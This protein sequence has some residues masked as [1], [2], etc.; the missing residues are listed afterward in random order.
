MF[1]N[2]AFITDIQDL[3]KFLPL[4]ILKIQLNKYLSNSIQPDL[5]W[6]GA[7]L[8]DLQISLQDKLFNDSKPMHLPLCISLSSCILHRRKKTN[9]MKW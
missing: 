4:E 7:R 5:H 8:N 1:E 2:R 3:S 6:A 9:D